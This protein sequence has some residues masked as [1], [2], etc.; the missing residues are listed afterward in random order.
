VR[1]RGLRWL[2]HVQ[3][4]PLRR[5]DDVQ[6]TSRFIGADAYARTKLLN[7]LASLALAERVRADQITVTTVHPGLTW[8]AMT[9]SMTPATMPAWRL[10]WPII[11]LL[12]RRGSPDKAARRVAFLA[13]S[14]EAD[15]YTGAYFE[16]P[17]RPKRLSGRELDQELQHRAWQLVSDLVAAA[18]TKRRVQTEEKKAT[19]FPR[20]RWRSASSS[21]R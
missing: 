4:R 5:F 1:Q 20:S 9:R 19:D 8:T 3:G 12:Q 21:P 11:R 18:P 13:A 2:P 14:P 17:P 10:A 16:R 7:V 6:S 15:S